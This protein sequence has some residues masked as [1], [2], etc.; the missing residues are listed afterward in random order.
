MSAAADNSAAWRSCS[1]ME[2]RKRQ[3]TWA[4]AR[5]QPMSYKTA[6]GEARKRKGNGVDLG[7]ATG[8]IG[9]DYKV[10]TGSPDECMGSRKAR[11]NESS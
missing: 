7:R 2:L 11:R 10:H 8:G 3:S 6:S 9:A 4:G 1:N 5:W